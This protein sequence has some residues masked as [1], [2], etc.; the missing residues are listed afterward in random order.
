MLLGF[1]SPSFFV[2]IQHFSPLLWCFQQVY[3]AMIGL[4]KQQ[5]SITGGSYA[6]R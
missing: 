1:L 5:H 6:Y 3:L 2:S 4:S